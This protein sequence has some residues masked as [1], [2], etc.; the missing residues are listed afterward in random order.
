MKKIIAKL[1]NDQNVIIFPNADSESFKDMYKVPDIKTSVPFEANIKKWIEGQWYFIVLTEEQKVQFKNSGTWIRTYSIT[2]M[3]FLGLGLLL[4]ALVFGLAG[5][6]IY[7]EVSKGL[8]KEGRGAQEMF[9]ALWP[10][11]K[12]LMGIAIVIGIVQFY[13]LI[14]LLKSGNS[15]KDVSFSDDSTQL[16][17]GFKSYKN[18]WR[19][20][21]IIMILSIVMVIGIMIK[22]MP[23]IIEAAKHAR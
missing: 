22:L 5:D 15:F 11:A 21:G 2:I 18:F 23:I 16:I 6:K 4:F 17:N 12:L 8:R 1:K 7:E 10:M 3:I 14:Q 20:N 19:I 9:E 13:A